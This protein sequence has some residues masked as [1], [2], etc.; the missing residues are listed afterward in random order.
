MLRTV[1]PA[2]LALLTLAA[3]AA[4]QPRQG[5]QPAPIREFDLPTIERLG[6]EIWRQDVLAARAT[7]A[8]L[9][10]VPDPAAAGVVG[11]LIAGGG[12]PDRVRFL[13]GS[14]EQLES[15][16]DVE[17]PATGEPR[18]VEPVDRR[19]TADERVRFEAQQAAARRVTRVCRPGYNTAVF[20]DIDGDGWLVWLLAPS[21]AAGVA[22]LGGHYRFTVSADGRTVERA[23][24][25]SASCLAIDPRQ[26][27]E[28]GARPVG[29]MGSHIVSPT[30]IETH[31][32]LQLLYGLPMY[33]MA[34]DQLWKI[35][36]GR[37]G[38][39]DRP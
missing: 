22:P 26:G 3:P 18:V 37:I 13:R 1:L 34:G 29:I 23:D 4:A 33:V 16:Y 35:V 27:L 32:F 30:P 6:R 15:A 11:W 28:P 12:P 25:L 38:K 5:G 36:D 9:A 2:L 8:L 39:V 10:R 14:G 20:P 24:A 31:V 19:L 21:P 17:V 7:D